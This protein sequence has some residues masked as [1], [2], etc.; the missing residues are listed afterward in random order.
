MILII[1]II[2]INNNNYDINTNNYDINTNNYDI[3]TNNYINTND[4]DINTNNYDINTNNYDINTNNEFNIY[5][6]NTESYGN[7]HQFYDPVQQYQAEMRHN[8]LYGF[9]KP[10]RLSDQDKFRQKIAQHNH[11]IVKTGKYQLGNMWIYVQP[12]LR[13]SMNKTKTYHFAFPFNLPPLEQK[14]QN[15]NPIIHIV[16]LSTFEAV[17]E[18]YNKYPDKEICFLNFANAIKPGG[19]YLNGRTA[20]EEQLCR[21][22]LLYPTLTKNL[23]M[24]QFNIEQNLHEC[25]SNYMIYSPLVLFFRDDEFNL[26]P[27]PFAVNVITSPAVD[28]R[29]RLENAHSLMRDRIIRILELAAY[30]ENRV[31]VLGAFGCGVFKNDP[32]VVA[33]LFKEA[34]NM[35]QFRGRFD[36][37]YFAIYRSDRNVSNFRQVFYR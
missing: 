28:N 31:L 33:K 34:I 4:H 30:H 35:G 12:I 6:A 8:I 21:Q 10:Y 3:S 16:P 18:L 1:I 25:G 22:S 23:E 14:Y 7:H 20:Q 11:E 15:V 19:G 26:I 37:I 27:E 29:N 2:D 24:Y 13:T 9:S 5:Y 17:N 36:C 32:Y